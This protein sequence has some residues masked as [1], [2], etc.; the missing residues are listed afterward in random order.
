[1]YRADAKY[2]GVPVHGRGN[3][4]SAVKNYVSAMGHIDVALTGKSNIRGN[5]G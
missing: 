4:Y 1:M 3:C 2:G 5:K